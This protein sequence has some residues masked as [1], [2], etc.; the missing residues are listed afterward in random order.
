MDDSWAWVEE[1]VFKKQEREMELPED[2][3][4]YFISRYP[5]ITEMIEKLDLDIEL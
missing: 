2:L 1:I 5:I 4:F 3:Y